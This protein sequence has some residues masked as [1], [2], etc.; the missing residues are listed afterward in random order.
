MNGSRLRGHGILTNALYDGRLVWNRV[1]MLKD[2][3]TGKRISRVNPEDSWQH[4]AAEHLRIVDADS[5]AA[6]QRLKAERGGAKPARH[7]RKPRHMLSGLL[8]C[9]ACGGGLSIKDRDTKGRV[10]VECTQHRGAQTCS[11]TYTY[12]LEEVERTL[13]AGLRRFLLDPRAIRHYLDTYTKERKRLAAETISNRGSIE[14]RL[15]EVTRA[16]ER[17]VDTLIKSHDPVDT[18]IAPI[19]KLELEKRALREELAAAP[20]PINVVTLHPAALERYLARVDDLAA[21]IND[22]ASRLPEFAMLIRDLVE[23]VTVQQR[24]AGA[25]MQLDVRGKLEKLI[26]VDPLGVSGLGDG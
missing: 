8:R 26:G 4:A 24:V 20:E 13:L 18:L 5:F 14:R 10:R 16:I 12:R 15:A 17:L 1:R 2:P 11:N 25:P 6:A 23:S 9:G 21:N 19:N 7:C 22:V 3:D